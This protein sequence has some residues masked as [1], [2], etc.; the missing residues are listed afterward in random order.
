MYEYYVKIERKKAREEEIEATGDKI[1][2]EQWDAAE[3]WADEEERKELERLEEQERIT[4]SSVNESAEQTNGEEPYD[5]MK[6]P[7]AVEW[8]EKYIEEEKE[9]HGED[10]GDDLSF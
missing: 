5:P 6:D 1:E 7:E 9:K 8:M 3:A 4:A 2:E 10:F